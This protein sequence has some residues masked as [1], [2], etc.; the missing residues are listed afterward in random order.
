MRVLVVLDALNQLEDRDHARL[1][2]WLPWHLFTG[3]LRLIVSS[4]RLG[5]PKDD[6]Q[7]I[8]EDP[9]TVVT[10]QGWKSLRIKPLTP[11]ERHRM[12]ADY[13]I[14]FGKKLDPPRAERLASSEA[15]ANPLYLKIILDELR[16]TGTHDN[17]DER[18]TDY[19]T[20]LDIPALW[21]K[22][23]VRYERDYESDRPGLVREALALIWSARRGLSETELLRMLRATDKPQM[24][25]AFW[26]PLR[27]ALE[28]SLL[29]CGGIFS[30]AHDFLRTAVARRYVHSESSAKALRL[31]L[32]AE[33]DAQPVSIRSCDELLWLLRKAEDRAWLRI[34]L[35]DI[36]RFKCV[37]ATIHNY[38]HTEMIGY[39]IWLGEERTMGKAYL[40]S[41][42]RWSRGLN[43][44][45]YIA[46]VAND[47]ALFLQNAALYAKAE[48]LIRQALDID[49]HRLGRDHNRVALR[50]NN[51]ARL[52]HD[53]NRLMEAEPLMR[54]ALTIDEQS[55]GAEHPSVA[56]D[57]NNL[58]RLLEDS[59]R[60]TEAEPLMR[61]A[62]AIN[63]HSFGPDH[64]QVGICLNN[65]AQLLQATNRPVE[66]ERLMRQAA[67]IFERACGESSSHT[68]TALN[69]LAQ[70][71]QATNRLAEAEPLMR[72]VLASD[73]QTFGRDHP[74][75]ARDLTNLASLIFDT[76]R[77]ADAEPLMRR[78][79]AIN[80]H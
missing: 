10:S 77:L 34:S 53:G 56:R 67:E 69:N 11:D 26:S 49:E 50:L 71:L 12:I 55:L 74:D 32:A 45:E 6:P 33:F 3:P 46:A 38:D 25:L 51:L 44:R 43:D 62:L 31:R 37:F 13:L 14:H 8:V 47:L 28:E 54:R 4:L 18:L 24:P 23:L 73:E 20:A 59:N 9:L 21:E 17:L 70:L 16:V 39:W 66:A 19:L 15:A 48:P 72:R 78:A 76:G 79:L 64:P 40:A 42:A 52:L 57:L 65:L 27:A 61:R 2:G 80:E 1:L 36:D 35:L 63:E 7:N 60:L 5:P 68:A 41:F 29:N 30:F 22:I 58:A 75:V